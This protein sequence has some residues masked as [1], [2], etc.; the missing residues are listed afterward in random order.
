MV[1]GSVVLC[2][3]DAEGKLKFGNVFELYSDSNEIDFILKIEKRTKY[4][5]ETYE[6]SIVLIGGYDK[7]SNSMSECI[8]LDMLDL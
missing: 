8:G 4:T 3:D 2:D 7:D 5:Y 6:H 1:D